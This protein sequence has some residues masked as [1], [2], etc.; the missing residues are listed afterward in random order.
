MEAHAHFLGRLRERVP[1]LRLVHRET[2]SSGRLTAA[3]AV[4]GVGGGLVLAAP[5]VIYDWAR[6]ATARSS[7]R[8]RSP[9]GCSG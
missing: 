3:G 9:A 5:L 8:W 1:H 4:A 2:T 7:C 6:A